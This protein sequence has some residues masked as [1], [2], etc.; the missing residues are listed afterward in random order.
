MTII[1]TWSDDDLFFSFDFIIAFWPI[2]QLT[3][4]KYDAK[5]ENSFLKIINGCDWHDIRGES[6]SWVNTSPS[7]RSEP[8]CKPLIMETG[9]RRG[10]LYLGGQQTGKLPSDIPP[11]TETVSHTSLRMI[12]LLIYHFSFSLICIQLFSVLEAVF[13][14]NVKAVSN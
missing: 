8:Q 12:N 13:N 4:D 3:L 9:D 14:V 1:A 6:V 7:V 5:H 10:H 11:T 2:W